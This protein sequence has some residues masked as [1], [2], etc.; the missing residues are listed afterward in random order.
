VKESREAGYLDWQRRFLSAVVAGSRPIVAIALAMLV[1]AA[2]IVSQ[3]ANPFAAYAALLKGSF[4]SVNA[5]ANTCVRTAPLLLGGLGIAL[6]IQGGL[7]NIG[8]EGQLYVG[9]AAATAVGLIPLPVPAWLHVTLAL[10]AGI[11][12]G[13]LMAFIPGYLRAYRGVSEVVVTL[14][15][16]YIGLYFVG[17]LVEGPTPLHQPDTFY[18]QSPPILPSALLPRLIKGTSLHAGIIFGLVLGV[19]LYFLLKFTRFGFRIRMVGANPE[20]ARYAGV[21]VEPHLLVIM[22]IAGGFAGLMGSG[23]VLGLKRRLF[24]HFSGGLGY[25]A[26]SVALLGGG[27]PLGVILS[28]F[29]FGALRA[30]AGLMQQTVGVEKAMAEVIQA[31]AILF[32][33]GI[34]FARSSGFDLQKRGVMP[35]KDETDNGV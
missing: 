4:G 6:G 22:L 18:P 29:F 20:A 24:D 11:A 25:H 16:N 3:G 26:I 15:L 19:A 31:L 1:S 23:E 28:A 14:M 8:A 33:V 5:L 10:L 17:F 21:K 34:G 9:A 27:D 7:F 2:L 12:G 30:G 32:V 35:A 13:A